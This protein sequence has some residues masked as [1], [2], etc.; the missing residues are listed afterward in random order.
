MSE[1]WTV[2]GLVLGG[3]LAYMIGRLAEAMTWRTHA[4]TGIAKQSAGHR[5]HVV[6]EAE[7][8]ELATHARGY[9]ELTRQRGL[10]LAKRGTKKPS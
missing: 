9:R 8:I 5:F 10:T 2:L 6:A 7:Y 3:A 4:G 1:A